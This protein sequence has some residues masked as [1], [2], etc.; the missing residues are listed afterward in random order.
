MPLSYR[1]DGEI[2]L[3]TATGKIGSQEQMDFIRALL[4]NPAL[5]RPLKVLRDARGRTGLIGNSLQEVEKFSQAVQPDMLMAI[6]TND[7]LVFGASR[8]FQ[9]TVDKP[10]NVHVFRC[11]DE[12]RE[13]LLQSSS[14]TNEI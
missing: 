6:V 2:V 8:V 9:A 12:A 1:I 11:F 13:W 10:D 7:D 14:E 3:V 5:P 4:S